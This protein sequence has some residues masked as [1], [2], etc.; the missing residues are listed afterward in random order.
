MIASLSCD[1]ILHTLFTPCLTSLWPHVHIFFCFPP[2]VKIKD[3]CSSILL[4]ILK[5][6]YHFTRKHVLKFKNSHALISPGNLILSTRQKKTV[7][8][9]SRFFNNPRKKQQQQH[10]TTTLFI[11]YSLATETLYVVPLTIRRWKLHSQTD[12]QP[13]SQQ[14]LQFIFSHTQQL[15]DEDLQC[16]SVCLASRK[17]T[18][19][20]YKFIFNP[21]HL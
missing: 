18:L 10:E 13:A 17:E 5:A 4:E 1:I 20:R 9:V 2:F 12:R 19:T 8:N 15:D 21:R 16:S 6:Y 7:R 3:S 11:P 14:P